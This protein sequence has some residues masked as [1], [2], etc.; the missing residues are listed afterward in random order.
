[1]KNQSTSYTLGYLFGFWMV[2]LIIK[3]FVVTVRTILSV[4]AFL[5]GFRAPKKEPIGFHANR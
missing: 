5:L 2:K 4:I 1:M 3:L